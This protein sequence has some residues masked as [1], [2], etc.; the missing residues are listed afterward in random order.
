MVRRRLTSFGRICSNVDDNV[1][2][3]LRLAAQVI[4]KDALDAIRIARLRVEGRARVMGHHAIAASKR[5]LRRAPDVVL[6]RRLHVPH[7]ARVAGQLP[8][9]ERLRDRVLVADR[10]A[11]G[12]HEPGA[13]LEVLEEL[14]VDEA[15]RALVQWAVHGD[16]V[17]LG[18]EVA[19]SVTLR[20]PTA[21]CASGDSVRAWCRQ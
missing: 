5:V 8:A 6:R 20:A 9:L 7:V 13:P 12:V 11:R 2:R 17:A 18:D 21:F 16:D 15:P 14:G 19:R 1:G 4:L 10:A 3:F